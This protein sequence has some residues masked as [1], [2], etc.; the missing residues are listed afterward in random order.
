[1]LPE[2][3]CPEKPTPAELVCWMIGLPGRPTYLELDPLERPARRAWLEAIAGRVLAGNA[4]TVSDEEYESWE[5]R[6]RSAALWLANLRSSPPYICRLASGGCVQA[7]GVM[8]RA[9]R[10]GNE[11]LSFR[12]RHRPERGVSHV[13]SDPDLE[14]FAGLLRAANGLVAKCKNPSCGTWFPRT[15][16]KREYCNPQCSVRARKTASR[17]RKGVKPRQVIAPLVMCPPRPAQ[18]ALT[19]T[20]W[21]AHKYRRP[22]KGRTEPK[23]SDPVSLLRSPA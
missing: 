19:H 11:C 16:A 22:R 9:D 2:T 12:A 23:S 15:T 21:Q 14:H 18:G 10:H 17:R 7:S 3:K 20:D 5:A 13:R 6:L 8:K 1:M 4:V